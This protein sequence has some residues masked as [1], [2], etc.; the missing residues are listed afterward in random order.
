MKTSQLLDRIRDK[1]HGFA[2]IDHALTNGGSFNYPAGLLAPVRVSANPSP[3]IGVHIQETQSVFGVFILLEPGM[4]GPV[5]AGQ[6][7]LI[8]DLRAELRAAL[9]GWTPDPAIFAPMQYA[10]GELSPYHGGIF[11]WREDFSVSHEIRI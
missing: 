3:F 10:G 6:A 11:A 9:V 1:C 8:D 2:T 4:D 7:D 5:G